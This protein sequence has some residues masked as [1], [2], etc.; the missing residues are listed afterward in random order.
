MIQRAFISGTAIHKLFLQPQPRYSE[1]IDLVQRN[2]EPIKKTLDH[3]RDALSFLGEPIVKQKKH[4][5]T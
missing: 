4:N 2:P 1:D 5:N 3:L